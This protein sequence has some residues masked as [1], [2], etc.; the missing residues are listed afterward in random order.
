MVMHRA[1]WQCEAQVRDTC[2]GDTPDWHHR[3]RRGIGRHGPENGL[4][5][6]RPCHA[7]IHAHPELARTWGWIVPT[8][9]DP[10][11]VQAMVRGQWRTLTPGGTY[12]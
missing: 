12:Q 6:C 5:A 9:T 8:T 1:L 10:T 7:W 4:A 11:G 3:Q 2:T